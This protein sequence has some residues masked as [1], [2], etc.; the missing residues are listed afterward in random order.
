MTL[1]PPIVVAIVS[2]WVILF[3]LKLSFPYVAPFIFGLLLALIIDVPVSFL[4]SKGWSRAFASL[5]FVALSFL[6]LPII[7]VVL[8][9]GVWHE[10]QGLLAVDFLANLS[11]RFTG[12]SFAILD[13]IPLARGLELANLF[14]WPQIIFQWAAAIPDFFLFCILTVFSAYFFCRDKKA[15]VRFVVGQLPQ[16]KGFSVRRLYYDTS[17][18]FWRLIRVQLLLM[19]ISTASSMVFFCFLELPYPLLSGFL[20]GFFDLIPVFGPGLVYLGLAI[21]QFW[22]GNS[23][24]ALA[25]GIGYLILLLLRQWGEPH[26]LGDRLGLHP[27]AALLG[28]YAGFRFWG[29]L[30]AITGPILLVSIK[31][32]MGR[33]SVT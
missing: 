33:E 30:G 13:Q 8:L 16:K 11:A 31:A 27:L 21:I 20:V 1:L 7:V 19:L 25:L 23:G 22:L 17:G 28:L 10:I 9:V 29:P 26:L 2:F 12:D 14:S 24:I 6:A 15:L 3:L 5:L 32:F 18:A 4:E